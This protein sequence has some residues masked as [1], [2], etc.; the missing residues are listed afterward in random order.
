MDD[1]SARDYDTAVFQSFKEV[2]IAVRAAGRFGEDAIG[3]VLMRDAFNVKNG[4]LTDASGETSEQEAMGHLF[5][6]AYG[7]YRNPTG[8]RHVALKDPVE[9]VEMIVIASHLLRIVD[10]RVQARARTP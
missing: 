1:I 7:L 8:H 5:A 6:G 9:A 4:P 10:G 3:T 2:E